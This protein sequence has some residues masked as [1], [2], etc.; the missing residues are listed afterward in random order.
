[1]PNVLDRP[2]M[3][4]ERVI[5]AAKA[6]KTKTKK[7]NWLLRLGAIAGAAGLISRRRHLL[8][9][10]LKLP[11]PQSGF[12]I[13]RDIGIP[14]PDGIILRADHYKPT[15]PGKFP[16]ILIRTPYGREKSSKLI[17][18]LYNFQNTYFAERGYNVIVQ[19]VRG[20]F[21]SGGKFMPMV[22]ERTDGLAT[23]KWL[24]EQ[25]WFDGN[26]AMWGSSYLGFVQWAIAGDNPPS[27]KAF[28]PTI[29]G[30]QFYSSTHPGGSFAFD[31]S[32]RW[33]YLLETMDSKGELSEWQ[34]TRRLLNRK[35]SNRRMEIGYSSLPTLES[36]KL[37]TG[38]SLDYYRVTFDEDGR[39]EL[40]KIRR[41]DDKVPGVQA[42]AHFIGGWYD[43]FIKELLADYHTLVKAGRAPYL[44]IGEFTHINPKVQ[45]LAVKEGLKWFDTHIKGKTGLL[46]SK[47]VRIAIVGTEEWREMEHF[48]PPATEKTWFLQPGKALRADAPP[49]DATPD[50]YT[51]D[52]NDPTPAIGGPRLAELVGKVDNRPLE[53][54]RDVL[55]YTTPP[56]TADLEFIGTPR[57]TLYVKSNR[58]YTDFF[59]RV[60][61]VQPDG[62]SYNICDGLVRLKPGDGEVQPDGSL[63]I[64]LTLDPTACRIKAGHQLRVLV[65]SGAHPRFARNPGTGEPLGKETHLLSAD[66][67]IF[68]DAAHPSALVLPVTN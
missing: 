48:P 11:P 55:T 60:T 61:D 56:L 42:P 3:L 58:E 5:E 49:A 36:D 30:S 59:G 44:T 32:L 31:L 53:G 13:S 10:L 4:D 37:V 29:T 52:P 21:G 68:H 38:K 23:V 62:V 1:M 12:T 64:E 26:L 2:E 43:I 51:F 50:R 66:Q 63:K 27:L 47:P 28:M 57:L 7:P 33:A 25:P 16:T 8:A 40:W 22:D 35:A 39:D 14:M 20:R 15:A 65:A 6:N 54:R 46:R 24:E 45:R 41:H 18:L 34:A 9:R 19:D 17:G 67:T